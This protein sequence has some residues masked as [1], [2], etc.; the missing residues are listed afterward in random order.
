MHTGAERNLNYCAERNLKYSGDTVV[1]AGL[2]S[3]SFSFQCVTL[4]W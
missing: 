3:E 4:H 1:T 2:L